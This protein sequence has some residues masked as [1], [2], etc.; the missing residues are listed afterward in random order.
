MFPSV[1]FPFLSFVFNEKYLQF[2]NFQYGR[3]R[4]FGDSLDEA[5]IPLIIWTLIKEKAFIKRIL[6]LLL[7]IGVIFITFIS[8]WRTKIIIL[9]F[10]LFVSTIMYYK[11]IKKYLLLLMLGVL[12]T[13]FTS[14][15]FSLYTVKTD[16]IDRFL[17]NNEIEKKIISNRIN[18]W[19]EAIEMGLSSPITGVGLGNYYDNLPKKSK[20]A[21]KIISSNL[22]TIDDPHN[23]F[24][25]TFA[26]T[27]FL[28]LISLTLLLGY[29]FITDAGIFKK[30]QS[31]LQ[32]F[33]IIFWGLFI[34]GLFNPWMYFSYLMPFW[35]IRGFIEKYKM[36]VHY[37]KN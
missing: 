27:G 28:G 20:Q 33:I 5:F 2:F 26:S 24:V 1:I 36:I 22:I 19:K 37:E 32:T 14:S 3:N 13:I 30:K 25:S 31:I 11:Y 15:N 6:L 29:F 23:L 18:Y 4:F 34:F 17:F 12:L 21:N 16:I 7:M 35:L 8:N 10:S 9:L